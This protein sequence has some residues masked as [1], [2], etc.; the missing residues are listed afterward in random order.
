MTTISLNTRRR[1]TSPILALAD[2]VS[3]LP[4]LAAALVMVVTLNGLF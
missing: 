2:L 4:A 1:S 3:G